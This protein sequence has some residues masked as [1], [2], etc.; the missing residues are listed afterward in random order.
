MRP[1]RDADERE[2]DREDD[3]EEESGACGHGRLLILLCAKL[4]GEDVAR[5]HADRE[6]YGLNDR[7]DGEDDPDRSC[8]ARPELR[9]EERIGCVVDGRYEHADDR[10]HGELP[11]QAGHGCLRH[12]PVMDKSILLFHST[13]P[14]GKACAYRE[15]RVCYPPDATV[16]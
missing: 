10:R 4:P 3:S 7:H 9:D 6:A 15:K 5:S 13:H 1:E 14:A 16:V 2:D 11:D 12:L 8:R